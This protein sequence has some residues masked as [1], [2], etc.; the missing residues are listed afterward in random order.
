MQI[1]TITQPVPKSILFFFMITLCLMLK[2]NLSYGEDDQYI[3]ARCKGIPEVVFPEQDLPSETDKKSLAGCSSENLYYGIDMPV[4][5]IKARKC[6]FIE[7]AAG[8]DF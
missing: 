7:K 5:F 3:Y 6:A 4:D 1:K 8:D 2:P